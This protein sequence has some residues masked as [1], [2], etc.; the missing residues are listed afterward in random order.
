MRD[1]FTDGTLEHRCAAGHYWREH[2]NGQVT[3]SWGYGGTFIDTDDPTLCPEPA[4]GADRLYLCGTCDERHLPGDG[5]AGMSCTPWEFGSG[6]R[7]ECEL[8][9]PACREPAVWTRRWGDR[10][11]P[12]PDG[13]GSLYSL[14]RIVHRQHGERLVVYIAGF[15]EQAHVIDVRSGEP[16]VV[17]FGS[18]DWL[19]TE[20]RKATVADLPV[21]LRDAWPRAPRAGENGGVSTPWLLARTN[22]DYIALCELRERGLVIAADHEREFMWAVLAAARPGNRLDGEIRE[23]AR[24]RGWRINDVTTLMALHGEAV[25]RIRDHRPSSDTSTQLRLSF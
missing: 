12:W 18:A 23:R 5:L 16:L 8:P 25:Q 14:W 10:H 15:P 24:S 22:A 13:P 2:P 7:A 1:V 20:T 3:P 11:L 19:A 4:T 9:A 17:P 6:G 21:H